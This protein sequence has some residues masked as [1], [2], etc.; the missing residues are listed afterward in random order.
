MKLTTATFLPLALLAYAA[1]AQ[2]SAPSTQSQ[3]QPPT[4]QAPAARGAP[5]PASSDEK[6]AATE[7]D[8]ESCGAKWNKKLAEYKKTLEQNKNYRDYFEKWKNASAQRP[9]MLAIPELT[10]ASYRLCMAQ[11]LGD[12]TA[13]CPGGWPEDK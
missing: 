2:P 11:C 10:R 13:T 7:S 4:A 8:L 3:A 1:S 12:T 5:A 6:K 9:P